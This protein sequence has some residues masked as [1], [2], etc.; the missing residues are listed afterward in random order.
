MDCVASVGLVLGQKG[1]GNR[2]VV[3]CIIIVGLLLDQYWTV[4]YQQERYLDSSGLCRTSRSGTGTVEN[5]VISVGL[6]VGQK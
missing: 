4:S 2:T 1:T 3:D 6:V 5:Y